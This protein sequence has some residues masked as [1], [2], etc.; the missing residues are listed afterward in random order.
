ME[1]SLNKFE[2]ESPRISWMA[3]IVSILT[4]LATLT[5]FVALS[6]NATFMTAPAVGAF[7]NRALA[8]GIALLFAMVL[9]V[10]LYG[11]SASTREDNVSSSGD[12]E[13]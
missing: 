2:Q 9:A 11:M 1:L 12:R 3:W 7:G 10:W 13:R 8:L 6:V 4:T 5:F